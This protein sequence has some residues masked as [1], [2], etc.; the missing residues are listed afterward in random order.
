MAIW[1]SEKMGDVLWT[2]EVIALRRAPFAEQLDALAGVFTRYKAHAPG[3]GSTSCASVDEHILRLCQQMAEGSVKRFRFKIKP[4]E[5][6]RL[7]T[8][9]GC[10]IHWARVHDP[11][12]TKAVAKEYHISPFHGTKRTCS[13]AG[14]VGARPTN[15]WQKQEAG[16]GAA[17]HNHLGWQRAF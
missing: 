17:P 16:G 2:R 12:K 6:A 15:P 10:Q 11:A 14:C 13:L 4:E 7:L 3:M 8:I 9:L 5:P 1:V